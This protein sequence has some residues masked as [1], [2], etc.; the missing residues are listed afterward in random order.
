[1]EYLRHLI[2]ARGVANEPSKISVVQQWPL[3]SNAK[4]LREFWGLTSYYRRFI[5]HYG[6]I[7]SLLTQLL[8]KGVQF[9]WTT[10]TQE[11]FEVSKQALVQAPILA[12]PDFSKPFTVETNASDLGFGVVLMQ[13]GHPISYLSKPIHGKIRALSTYEKECMVMLLAIE[14]WRP[15]MQGQ[16]FIIKTNDRSLLFLIEQRASTKLQ[17]IPMLKLMDLNFSIQYK[18]GSTNNVA[19]ALSRQPE[20]NEEVHSISI[21]IPSWLLRLQES[22]DSDPEA[23]KLLIELSLTAENVQGFNLKDGVI[24]FRDKI[25]VGNNNLTQN[26]IMQALHSSAVGGH[27]GIQATYHRVN[28]MFAWPGLKAFATEYV[29]TCSICQQAKSEH[30]K[31]PGLL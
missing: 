14:K 4:Q 29:K 5:R 24:K 16:H 30:V 2:T 13:E 11:A 25:W 8:K 17:Q 7:N 12:V 21:G 9:Q 28:S 10:K 26:H 22:Y 1:L 19:D 6:L 15:Y 23:K 20:Q 3:P 31:L 27:S 18:K